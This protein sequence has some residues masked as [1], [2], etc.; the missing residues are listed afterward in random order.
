MTFIRKPLTTFVCSQLHPVFISLLSATWT[1][2]TATTRLRATHPIMITTLPYY[3][4]GTTNHWQC[5]QLS[6]TPTKTSLELYRPSS[7]NYKLSTCS[8]KKHSSKL[9]RSNNKHSSKLS[10]SNSNKSTILPA[11]SMGSG[12]KR[13]KFPVSPAHLVAHC[14]MNPQPYHRSATHK[15]PTGCSSPEKWRDSKLRSAWPKQQRGSSIIQPHSNPLGT[16]QPCST[17]RECPAE[18]NS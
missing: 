5:L 10:S 3:Q 17:I 18:C 11:S 14:R 13:L 9:S 8:S 4:M 6:R 16:T 1:Q 2:P 12:R 7:C 15:S